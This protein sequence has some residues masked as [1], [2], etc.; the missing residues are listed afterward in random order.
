MNDFRNKISEIAHQYK[1]SCD[2]F[3]RAQEQ[4]GVGISALRNM[5]NV[6]KDVRLGTVLAVL[7]ASGYE[8]VLK[9]KD[10]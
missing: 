10:R 5:I 6:N 3:A 9:R 7:D 2:T 4:S 8:L 1:L